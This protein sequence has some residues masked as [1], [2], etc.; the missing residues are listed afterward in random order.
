M[1]NNQANIFP[2]WLLEQVLD[3]ICYI[4]KKEMKCINY[5]NTQLHC[6]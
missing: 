2:N 3:I 6:R 1:N 5:A 4:G